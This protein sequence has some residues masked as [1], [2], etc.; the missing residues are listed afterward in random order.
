MKKYY[1]IIFSLLFL[2]CQH[3]ETKRVST[4]DFDLTISEI[5]GVFLDTKNTVTEPPLSIDAERISLKDLVHTIFKTDTLSFD[6]KDDK[7][8][9][10]T[11]AVQLDFK[12]DDFSSK[13]RALKSI[14]KASDLDYSKTQTPLTDIAIVD[15]LKLYRYY[16]KNATN[17][18]SKIYRTKDSIGLENISL[19]KIASILNKEF[20][21]NSFSHNTNAL[22]DFGFKFKSLDDV[23]SIFKNE[24][25]LEF[26]KTN[27]TQTTYTIK[28][29][30]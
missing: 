30:K 7:I 27:E 20:N 11:Y 3:E 19:K 2:C 28:A 26:Q 18:Q 16:A 14:L 24:L 22:I 13:K 6:F 8:A 21:I 25:G 17:N 1:N 12:N 29:I 5:N 10:Q 9:K 15:T 4:E 23:K